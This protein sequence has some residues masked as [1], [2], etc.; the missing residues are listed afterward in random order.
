MARTQVAI[1]NQAMAKRL[2]PDTPIRHRRGDS[3]RERRN[4]RL[5]H[6]RRRRRRMSGIDGMSMSGARCRAPSCHTHTS[7]TLQHRYDV[8]AWR[9]HRRALTRRF[10][11]QIHASDPTVPLFSGAIDGEVARAELLA[12][13]AVRVDVLD[14]RRRSR[15][16]WHRSASTACS[17]TRSR[18]ARR[19]SACA[20]RLARAGAM[21]CAVRGAGRPA[22]RDRHRA[23]VIGAFA[24]RASSS[25]CSTTSLPPIRSA[26]PRPPRSSPSS[27]CSRL[28]SGA[29]RHGRRP[30]DCAARRVIESG[31]LVACPR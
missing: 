6:R 10:A 4:R 2:W 21:C 15:S 20:W 30:D 13:P 19:R 26:L 9:R 5:D 7:P 18:S 14:V 27:R 1:V 8:R 12:V 31:H 23:A 17:R 16:C 3:G 28:P 24:T 25:A 29:A 11:E 22:R